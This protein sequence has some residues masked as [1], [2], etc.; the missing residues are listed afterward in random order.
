LPQLTAVP[1]QPILLK[2]QREF[3]MFV[4]LR[5][6]SKWVL[7]PYRYKSLEQLLEQLNERVIAPAE[8]NVIKLKR[9][10]CRHIVDEQKAKHM[11]TLPSWTKPAKERL[12]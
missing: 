3:A 12:E 5:K 4:D 6:R 1:L 2:G 11:I 8:A 7:R 10:T 9:K